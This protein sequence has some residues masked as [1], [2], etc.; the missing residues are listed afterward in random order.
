MPEIN[1]NDL[2]VEH[3]RRPDASVRE[4]DLGVRITH[5]PS[6]MMVEAVSEPTRLANTAEALGDLRRLLDERESGSASVEPEVMEPTTI[7]DVEE[8]LTPIRVERPRPGQYSSLTFDGRVPADLQEFLAGLNE[9]NAEFP[10]FTIRI[11][12]VIPHPSGRVTIITEEWDDG[13]ATT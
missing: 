10:S 8:V 7:Q 13:E 1:K 9:G 3:I 5:T 12:A 6:G 11:V 2:R 4:G